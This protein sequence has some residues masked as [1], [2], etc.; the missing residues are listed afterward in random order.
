MF[1]C[2]PAFCRSPWPL[3]RLHHFCMKSLF[4]Y[5]KIQAYYCFTGVLPIPAEHFLLLLLQ[6]TLQWDWL[7]YKTCSIFCFFSSQEPFQ[8]AVWTR[9]YS[10]L[11]KQE[12]NHKTFKADLVWLWRTSHDWHTLQLS[13][14]LCAQF[15]S[16]IL[17]LSF[18]PHTAT[19]HSGQCYYRV[20]CGWKKQD[21]GCEYF[22]PVTQHSVSQVPAA[23]PVPTHSWWEG[24]KVCMVISWGTN[25]YQWCWFSIPPLF[26]GK[27]L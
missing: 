2:R 12:E 8:L 15:T 7:T 26:S 10:Q 5:L 9:I 21:R 14:A 11:N 22:S 6:G 25:W 17:S 13:S 24:F 27:D 19:K 23:A 1:S 16:Q 3:V 20:M 18:S 4:K